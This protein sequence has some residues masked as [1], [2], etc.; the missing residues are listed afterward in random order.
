MFNV[1]VNVV[2]R[3]WYA[4]VMEDVIAANTGLSGDNVS[5]LALLFYTDDSA[6]WSLGPE[7][8]QNANQYFCNFFWDFV[9][10]KPNTDKTETMSC[11]PGALRDLCTRES[12]KLRHEGTVESYQ[13]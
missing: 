3:K 11:H 6:V 8:L 2:I 7:W 9:D 5:Y 13:K 1:I 10:L 12:Y 4:D